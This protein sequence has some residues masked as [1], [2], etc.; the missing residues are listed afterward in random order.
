MSERERSRHVRKPWSRSGAR[1]RRVME[2][3]QS[4]EQTKLAAQISLKGDASLLK[5][6]K[7]I[8][9]FTLESGTN[10]TT[11]TT[12]VLRPFFPDH[13][14]E[15]V[16]EENF[17]TLWCKGNRGRHTDHPA[18]RH[19]IWTNQCPPPPSRHIFY[20]PDALP[21]AQPTVSKH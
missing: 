11:N 14:G 9:P 13:P 20:G 2:R 15:P 17:W 12:T 4:G 6:R 10:T 19:S 8:L 3:E 5:L 16:P 18:G 7:S 1:S 21:A